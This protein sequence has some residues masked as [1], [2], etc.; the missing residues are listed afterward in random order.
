VVATIE[1]L[2]GSFAEVF[3]VVLSV[4]GVPVGVK[5][6]SLYFNEVKHLE[7]SGLAPS[8][9]TYEVAVVVDP[10]DVVPES[11]EENN[12]YELSIEVLPAPMPY[13]MFV[14]GL[15]G[16]VWYRGFNGTEWGPWRLLGGI[17]LDGPSAAYF[18]DK[19]YVA[20]RGLNDTIWYGYVDLAFGNF[21]GWIYVP[22]LTPSRPALV[23]TPDGVLM[24][25]RG[26]GDE[27]WV[28]PLT[29]PNKSWI[30]LPGAT[31]DAPAVAALGDKVHVVVRGLDG[32]SLWHGVLDAR[33]WTFSGWSSI[34]GLTDSTPDLCVD[35]AS[36]VVYLAVKGLGELGGAV[37]INIYTESLGWH[38]WIVVPGGLTDQGPA[39]QVIGNSLAVVVKGVASESIWINLKNPDGTWRGWT[40]IDG[41]TNHQPEHIRVD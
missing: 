6:T 30:R 5:T 31:V 7:F 38:G 39:V 20:L 36:G 27:I 34:A 3:D 29:W 35:K 25:V 37:Y 15:E 24:F 21:S 13:Y 16:S 4:N 8:A 19:L 26:L 33:T 41:L 18:D 40:S 22:G 9:G 17:A 12:R 1:N 14:T 32:Y 2:G 28:Y 11:D 10:E 23:S